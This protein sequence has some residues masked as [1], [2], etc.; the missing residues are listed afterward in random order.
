MSIQGAWHLKSFVV[1]AADKGTELL[2]PFGENPVGLLVYCDGHVSASIGHGIAA[3]PFA[4][5]ESMVDSLATA[6]HSEKAAAFDAFVSYFGT[7]Q[8]AKDKKSVTHVVERSL[9][10]NWDGVEQVRFIGKLDEV[11]LQ[12]L[13]P[14]MLVNGEEVRAEINW[15]RTLQ[16]N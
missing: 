1:R 16:N 10:P 15:V 6:A 14:P 5:G 4:L 7:Y 13:T 11:E 3:K 2:K 9:L 12:L 8:V